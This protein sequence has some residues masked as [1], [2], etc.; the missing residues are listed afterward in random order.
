MNTGKY[1]RRYRFLFN[2]HEKIDE[3]T[4][5]SGSHLDFGARIYDSRIGRFFSVDPKTNSYPWQT[6]F[7]YHR[8]SPTMVIDFQGEGDPPKL[9]NGVFFVKLKN[10]TAKIIYNRG[11]QTFTGRVAGMYNDNSKTNYSVNLQQYG[12]DNI[13]S[14]GLRT[15]LGPTSGS[16]PFHSLGENVSNG[17]VSG[18]EPDESVRAYA[19]QDNDG[20]W[21]FGLGTP[22]ADAKTAFGGGIPIILNGVLY[23]EG[24]GQKNPEGYA[25]QNAPNV[26]KVL[27]GFNSKTNTMMLVVSPDELSNSGMTLDQIRDKLYSEGYDNLIGFDGGSSST[28]IQGQNNIIVRPDKIKDNTIPTGLRVEGD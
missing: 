9:L 2:G 28:L 26:G 27:V 11:M 23:G 8:N 5:T 25:N 17:V 13:L 16:N 19:S 14:A 3:I 6:P 12:Y 7:A 1:I 24:E 21:S 4:F 10:P 18:R 15:V 20:N 22:P